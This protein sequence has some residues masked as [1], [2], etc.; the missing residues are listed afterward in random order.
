MSGC[1]ECCIAVEA[2][3]ICSFPRG[4]REEK[5][6][7]PCSLYHVELPGGGICPPSCTAAPPQDSPP[8]PAHL[9]LLS[10]VVLYTACSLQVVPFRGLSFQTALVCAVLELMS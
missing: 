6:T 7:A 8:P 2:H 4:V 3:C 9:Q 10:Q 5:L 1:L